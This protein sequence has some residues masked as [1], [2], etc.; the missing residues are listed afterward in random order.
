MDSWNEFEAIKQLL[1]ANPRF[2]VKVGNQ[3]LIATRRRAFLPRRGIFRLL[4]PRTRAIVTNR[5]E[6]KPRYSVQP[7][8]IAIFMVIMLLGGLA[9]E[10]LMDRA[11][12]PRDYPPEFIYGLAIFYI[13]ALIVD[14][15]QTRKQLRALRDQVKS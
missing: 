4:L 7:D 3:R 9:V 12:Y 11:E 14:M 6:T 2:D 8:R 13:G 10:L 5:V 1:T 15:M